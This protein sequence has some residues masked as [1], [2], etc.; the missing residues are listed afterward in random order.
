[1]KQYYHHLYN[2]IWKPVRTFINKMVKGKDE[3]DNH[4]NHPWSI[5]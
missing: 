5:F 1:M 3:D 4:F 2:H